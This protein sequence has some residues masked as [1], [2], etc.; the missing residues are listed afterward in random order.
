MEIGILIRQ[1]SMQTVRYRLKFSADISKIHVA[2][3]FPVRSILSHNTACICILALG[4]IALN[5]P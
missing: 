3:E 2:A 1:G 5:K 4:K